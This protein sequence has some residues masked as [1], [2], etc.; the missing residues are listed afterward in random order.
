MTI[1][2]N[3]ALVTSNLKSVTFNGVT[4]ATSGVLLS[5]ILYKRNVIEFT[6]LTSNAVTFNFGELP[7]NKK[8]YVRLMAF[9][10]C[11]SGNTSVTLT[12]TGTPA[13]VQTLILVANA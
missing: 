8:I 10:Q 2:K 7:T 3:T 6:S 1:N 13:V 4:N 11:T 5:S 9:T 12:L